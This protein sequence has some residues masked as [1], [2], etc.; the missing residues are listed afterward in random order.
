M[1]REKSKLKINFKCSE[2]GC[3]SRSH[4]AALCKFHYDRIADEAKE[5]AKIG[6]SYGRFSDNGKKWVYGYLYEERDGEYGMARPVHWSVAP[7]KYYN[8]F[9]E[10]T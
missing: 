5:R 7:N 2:K 10:I 9:E 3:N 8:Y 6:Q 4:K 1:V